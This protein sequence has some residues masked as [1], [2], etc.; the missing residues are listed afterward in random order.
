MLI[1]RVFHQ[2]WLGLNP[3][4]EAHARYQ[5]TWLAHHPGWELRFWTEDNLPRSLRRSEALERLRH[6]VERSDI[7]RHELLWRFGG[8]YL[9]TDF[10]C[11]RSIEPLIDEVTFFIG[12]SKPGTP[13]DAFYGSVAGHPILDSTLD[14][15]V[16]V[17][18]YESFKPKRKQLALAIADHRDEVLFLEPAI[19]YPKE[20]ERN[21]AY[22]IHHTARGW[23]DANV[24]QQRLRG[25]K[26]KAQKWRS[27][28]EKAIEDSN[29]WRARCEHAEAELARLRAAVGAPLLPAATLDSGRGP[30]DLPTDGDGRHV[31]EALHNVRDGPGLGGASGRAGRG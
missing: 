15:L 2:I 17:D 8:V 24:L 11:L 31:G 14:K 25:I 9:D 29:H 1:P 10:E 26:R 20:T 3:F 18:F 30:A 5:D 13:H 22:A 16:A 4:P 7:L 23:K 21:R 19:L 6:P 27:R 28:Y 12:S